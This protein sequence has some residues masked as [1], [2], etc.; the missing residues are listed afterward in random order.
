MPAGTFKDILRGTAARLTAAAT[1]TIIPKLPFLQRK[2]KVSPKA[3]KKFSAHRRIIRYNRR[4]PFV[5]VHPVTG[6]AL[7]RPRYVHECLHATKGWREYNA[8][9][10]LPILNFQLPRS[11]G[12]RANMVGIGGFRNLGRRAKKAA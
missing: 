12:P 10:I 7:T 2:L 9:P 4:G 1:G 11:Y 3:G 8:G 5:S 6:K